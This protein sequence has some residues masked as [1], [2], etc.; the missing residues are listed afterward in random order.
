MKCKENEPRITQNLKNVAKELAS[1]RVYT[2]CGEKL[3]D[4]SNSR[5]ILE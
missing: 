5:F 4:F 3:N 1:D 2:I